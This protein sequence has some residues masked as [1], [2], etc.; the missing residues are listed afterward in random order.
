MLHTKKINEA[1]S[2]K[3]FKWLNEEATFRDSALVAFREEMEP[4]YKPLK[5]CFYYVV[6]NDEKD[7]LIVRT[8]PDESKAKAISFARIFERTSKN[9][10]QA[11]LWLKN[12]LEEQ[13]IPACEK[14]KVF[15]IIAKAKTTKGES[16]FARLAD[17]PIKGIVKIENIPGY[18]G[19]LIR[20]HLIDSISIL[21]R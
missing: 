9:E 10:L 17:L 11:H 15:F 18:G 19:P 20:I 2:I 1:E 7:L 21:E 5:G 6:Y 13:I 4:P 16:V 8:T 3:W 12:A 14:E